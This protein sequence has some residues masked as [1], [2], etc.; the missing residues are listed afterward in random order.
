[1]NTQYSKKSF[2]YYIER[3][4]VVQRRSN[5]FSHVWP[6]KY[7]IIFKL[8]RSSSDQNLVSVSSDLRDIEHISQVIKI[9][10][11]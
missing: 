11:T 9:M 5:P 1:M 7:I 10:K 6:I 3:A 8:S 2:F 4:D